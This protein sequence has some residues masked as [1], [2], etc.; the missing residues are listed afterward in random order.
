MI[1]AVKHHTLDFG[2][3]MER[4]ESNRF[5]LQEEMQYRQLHSK[6]S[7]VSGMGKTLDMSSS[8]IFFTTDNDLQLGKVVEVSVNWPARLDGTLPL[9]FVAVGRV[10]RAEVGRAA[11]KFDRYEFRTRGT[12]MPSL[13][14]VSA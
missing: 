2:G 11:L 7:A 3:R 8:G 1:G 14:A 4:R 13:K 5:P 10:V 6:G 12:G 9:K